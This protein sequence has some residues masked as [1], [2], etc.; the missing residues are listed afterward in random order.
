MSN[1]V[2]KEFLDTELSSKTE[3]RQVKEL[4][5]KLMELYINL[6]TVNQVDQLTKITYILDRAVTK[7]PE[8]YREKY[9]ERY[10]EKKN[11][12]GQTQ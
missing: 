10:F 7:L 11:I 2:I 1:K 6:K 4:H 12:P 8:K 9:M 3:P 5:C